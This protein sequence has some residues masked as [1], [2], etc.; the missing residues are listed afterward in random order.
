MLGIG[1]IQAQIAF[2]HKQ[3]IPAAITAIESE[4]P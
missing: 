4:L 3:V 2:D 1:D